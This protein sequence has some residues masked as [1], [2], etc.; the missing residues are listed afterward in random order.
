MVEILLGSWG[1][2]DFMRFKKTV[3]E[4]LVDSFS[5]TSIPTSRG[6]TEDSFKLTLDKF[7]NQASK[8]LVARHQVNY[9]RQN[10]CKPMWVSAWTFTGKLQE[11]SNYLE[12]YLAPVSNVFLA[13]GDLINILNQMV[14]AQWHRSMINNNFHSF[15]K[16]MTEVIEYMEK[17]EIL[18]AT[19]RQQ[20]TKKHDKV[21]SEDKTGKSKSKI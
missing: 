12:Y 7:K 2:K 14:P 11:I 20:S 15:T 5:T 19:N 9:L 21:E 16:S 3:T 17:L 8:D 10:L 6:I 18:E 1:K 4:G 13:E